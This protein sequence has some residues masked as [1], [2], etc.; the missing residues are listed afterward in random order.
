MNDVIRVA[1]VGCG[2]ISDLHAAAYL[3][4]P[5][6]EITAICEPNETARNQRGEAWGVP[7]QQ[8]YAS[9]DE[10]LKSAPV[11]MVDVLVPHHIHEE[12]ALQVMASGKHLSLQK[13]MTMSV[14]AATNLIEAAKRAN[15]V[16]K[17]FEN[18]VFYPPVVRAK[19]IIDSG[20]IGDVLSIHMRSHSG[21]SPTMWEIPQATAAWRMDPATCG[22]GPLVF[23]D[24]HHK[25][26]VGW[27]LG[28]RPVSVQADI[29]FW[30]DTPIDSPSNVMW[31]YET[32][33]IGSL[34][35]VFAP[36]TLLHSI[37]YAQDD[38]T[39]ITGTK[40]VVWVRGGHGRLTDEA[41]ISVYRD[42]ALRHERD[43]DRDWGTSFVQSGRHFIDALR[44]GQPPK[45]SGEEGREVLAIT[46]AVQEAART[47]CRVELD[48]DFAH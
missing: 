3:Q 39:V 24:G 13:P 16:F 17:V 30:Q 40:G 45:L 18:F 15:I 46:L 14:A 2:R 33:A 9:L 32:G 48:Y 21:Y 1:I 5:H 11:D 31:R 23:D 27:F 43:N 7:E 38:T 19:E 36:D 35:V 44:S 41:A 25:F 28:G 8:R 20:E 34:E 26:A 37:Y 42:G 47:G 22:G 4:H 6:A 12:V 29:G 10:L